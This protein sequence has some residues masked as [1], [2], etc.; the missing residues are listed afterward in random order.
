MWIKFERSVLELLER[1]FIG[2]FAAAQILAASYLT[3]LPLYAFAITAILV[4]VGIL[5]RHRIDIHRRICAGAS[6]L[7]I[8]LCTP[9]FALI[10]ILEER[11]SQIDN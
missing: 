3:G 7:L 6:I 9:I 4:D 10:L 5:T 11:A 2:L 8:I 1:L